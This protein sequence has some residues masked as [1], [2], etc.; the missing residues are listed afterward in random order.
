MYWVAT[1]CGGGGAGCG[2]EHAPT[3][4][5]DS[6]AAITAARLNS[7]KRSIRTSTLERLKATPPDA[8]KGNA[9]RAILVATQNL[10]SYPGVRPL[11]AIKNLA[12]TAA[13]SN[14]VLQSMIDPKA[15]A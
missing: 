15:I 10:S 7:L 5:A 1:G 11:P 8:A 6:T 9:V 4:V 3:N 12:F 2:W 14:L 13:C